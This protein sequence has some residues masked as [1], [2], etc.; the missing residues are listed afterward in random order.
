M[1]RKLLFACALTLMSTASFGQTTNLGGPLTWKTTLKSTALVP[2]KKMGSFDM[3]AIEAEDAI[4]DKDK[5]IPYRFGN[6]FATDFTLENAGEWESLPDGGRVWRLGLIS[7]GAITMNLLL[8]DVVIP[9]GSSLY[10]FDK[11]ETNRVGA[12][13]SRNNREDGLLGTELMHGDHMIVEFYEPAKSIGLGS[14]TIASVIHGYRTLTNVQ[15]NLAKA[16]NSSGN[17]NYDV[18]CPLGDLWKNQSSSVAMIV[19]GGSGICTGALIN[20][21]CNDGTPYFLTANHC[22]GGGVG[23]WAFRFNWEVAAGD[24]TLSCATTTNSAPIYNNSSNYDQTVNGATLLA[25][26]GL[27][28][29]GLLE[30]TNLTVTDAI[31]WGL[32]YAGWNNEDVNGTATEA[33]GIHHPS[34]DIKKI[35]YEADAPYKATTGGASVWWIDSWD[36]GVTEPGSSGSPL[37][38]QLGRIIGQLYGGAAACSGTSNNGQYD[39]Y[40]RLGV[41]WGL[42]ASEYLDPA[43]CGGANVTNPGFQPNPA[44]VSTPK[45]TADLFTVSP[46]PSTGIFNIDFGTADPTAVISVTDMTGRVI[47]TE[48]VNGL[49]TKSLDLSGVANGP[50]VLRVQT[51]SGTQMKT[52]ILDK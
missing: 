39:F 30:I 3:A 36:E 37:F 42:G 29:Y 19:V 21:S 15:N 26:S 11:N 9:E 40:G 46:N 18:N 6:K 38:D 23:S 17:C 12:Y 1:K 2:N 5:S 13:T 51:N 10:L 22:L 48:S 41:S 35:C 33:W 31:D 45:I 14:L 4:N 25:N 47:L 27:S 49:S 28:D 32:Y 24:A 16:L 34:G 43:A 7:N 8:E 50:Y 20:N 44:N 52:I